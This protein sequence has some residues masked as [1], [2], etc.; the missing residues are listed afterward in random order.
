MKI[1]LVTIAHGQNYGNRLQNYA[2]QNILEKRGHT[3]ETIRHPYYGFSIFVKIRIYIK[4]LIRIKYTK[5]ARR[6]EKFNRFNSK[7]IK[8]SKFY[9]DSGNVNKEISNYYDAFLCGSDQIWNPNYFIEKDSYFLT[10]VEGKKK[11]ALS[12]SFGLEKI[13]DS[14]EQVRI[15]ENLRQLTS[16]SV[17]EKSA[18][19]IVKD[20]SGRDAVHVIDPTLYLSQKEWMNIEKK[21]K[22]IEPNKYVLCY[23]LGKYPK[24]KIDRIRKKFEKINKSV[25]LLENEYTNLG[26][27]SDKEFSMD[28]AEFIWLIR[29]SYMVLTDSFHA[30]I[31]SIIFKKNFAVIK[32]DTIEEDISTRIINLIEMFNI[33]N[34]YYQDEIDEIKV[35]K[36]DYDFVGKVIK[37]EKVKFINFLEDS[38]S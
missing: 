6:I 20:L 37:E 2:I 15:A 16:I 22:G 38:L 29:N 12:A 9:V 18:Q 3:V 13:E 32:R 33:E 27:C 30:M 10:F 17:R 24:E 8:F 5:E 21:P 4:K 1:G 28:P 7:Y 23:L 11:I 14:D 35:A 36:M 34:A 25:I 26:L 19:K 31:F